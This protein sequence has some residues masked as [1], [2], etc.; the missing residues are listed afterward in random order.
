MAGRIKCENTSADINKIKSYYNNLRGIYAPFKE[1]FQE[2][3]RKLT[4]KVLLEE[5]SQSKYWFFKQR[6]KK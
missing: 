1:N 6:K 2:H 3:R 4:G 5:M